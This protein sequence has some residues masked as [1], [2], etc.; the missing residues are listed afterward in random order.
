MLSENNYNWRSCHALDGEY[1]SGNI[2]YMAD[3]ATLICYIKHPTLV[4]DLRF[5]P[6]IALPDKKWRMLLFFSEQRDLVFAGRQYPFSLG[7]DILNYITSILAE[8]NL[9][10]A[11]DWYNSWFNNYVSEV[12]SQ[13]TYERATIIR[14]RW[15]VL[16]ELIKDGK[17]THH[18]DD[19]MHS[20]YYTKPYFNYI[21]YYYFP[22]NKKTN[23]LKIG[24][25]VKCLC[26]G[27]EVTLDGDTF[28]CG[29]CEEKYGS[30]DSS[31]I[32]VCDA[33]GRR[34]YGP[35]MWSL[36]YEGTFCEDCAR[37]LKRT[38]SKCGNT[39]PIMDLRSYLGSNY[40]Q[41]CFQ[42]EYK[43]L[44]NNLWE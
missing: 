2:N 5:A 30:S 28:L 9:F 35:R 24:E 27:E 38:C 15:V 44:I 7:V 34:V 41:T 3:S 10:H 36:D 40:C 14:H 4:K 26:C 43:P 19:L 12:G 13:I 32:N 16:E 18:F 22:D 11:Q 6:G 23:Y 20:N 33:C 1:R 8:K 25:P 42:E 17:D 31:L 39:F 21:Q 37:E 29:Y